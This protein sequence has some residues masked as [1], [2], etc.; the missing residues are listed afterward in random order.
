MCREEKYEQSKI[1]ESL[2]G[3][4]LSDLL[5]LESRILEGEWKKR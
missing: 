3:E 5:L 4:T 2:V 1:L